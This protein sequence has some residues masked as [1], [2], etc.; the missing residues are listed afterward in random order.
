M[1]D[2]ERK[3]MLF[4]FCNGRCTHSP[5]RS[6]DHG[7]ALRGGVLLEVASESEI[8]DVHR[9]AARI[10]DSVRYQDGTRARIMTGV[11]MP[12][13]TTH[14]YAVLGS[15]PENGDAINNSS[16]RAPRLS[17]VFVPDDEL[18][19]DRRGR[20]IRSFLGMGDRGGEATVMEGLDSVSCSNPPPRVQIST[21]YMKTWCNAC[22]QE[23]YIAPQGPRWPGTGPNGEQWALSGDINICGCTPPPVFFAQRNMNMKFPAEDAGPIDG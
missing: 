8:S 5:R 20:M 9:R 18:S 13:D 7:A 22:K 6:G 16:H 4:A 3:G 10:D 17:T 19:I 21:L 11:G 2:Q 1:A 12:S 15:L 23:G 14:R